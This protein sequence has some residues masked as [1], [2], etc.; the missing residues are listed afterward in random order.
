MKEGESKK[1]ANP[2]EMFTDMFSEMPWHL[3]EQHD[4]MQQHIKENR[5]KYN[6]SQYSGL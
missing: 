1:R 2:T 4:Q 3:K 5:D 6:V